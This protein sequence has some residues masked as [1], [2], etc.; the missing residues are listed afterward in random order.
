M[1]NKWKVQASEPDTCD[2]PGCRYYE[3]WD[4][5]AAPED[6]VHTIAAFERMCPAHFDPDIPVG[7]ML[8]SDG[9]WKPLD[10]YIE[11]QRAWFRRLNHVEWL[12][13]RQQLEDWYTAHGGH[14]RG[15]LAADGK[16]PR[17][18]PV[19]YQLVGYADEMPETIRGYTSEPPTT[20][21]RPPPAQH[22]QDALHRVYRWNLEHNSRK[23]ET[24]DAMQA[25]R[26]QDG[27]WL[28]HAK[29]KWSWS[30]H[31]DNRVLRINSGGQLTAQQR[32][33]VQAAADIQHGQGRTVVEG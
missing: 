28:D 10:E 26:P 9:H 15:K 23:N 11:Y 13:R 31:G 22:R 17:G 4:A 21:S 2:P 1:V 25:Q 6:R 24:I 12:E 3:V 14:G 8:W 16:D 5:F 32:G 18:D 7:V 20:G 29:V 19:A 33:R 27:Y 30:G